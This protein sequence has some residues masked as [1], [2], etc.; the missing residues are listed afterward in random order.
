MQQLTKPEIQIHVRGAALIQLRFAGR[1]VGYA[2]TYQS[3]GHQASQLDR[4]L[5]AIR[6]Q[7]RN[8]PRDVT[9]VVSFSSS[10]SE[11]CVGGVTG[12]TK[13][14]WLVET[15]D[16]TPVRRFLSRSAAEWFCDAVQAYDRLLPPSGEGGEW[17]ADQIDWFHNHP[18]PIASACSGRLTVR[19]A[20]FH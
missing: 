19:F 11:K 9:A 12:V 15:A 14:A 20:G 5:F 6:E 2:M 13:E 8:S 4:L 3:A 10:V 7:G 16:G 18:A 1:C 17:T